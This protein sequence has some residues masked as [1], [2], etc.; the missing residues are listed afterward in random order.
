M[1][2]DP[3][4]QVGP[5]T[6]T[7]EGLRC[8]TCDYNLT[9]LVEEVCPECGN[10]FDR[11]QMIAEM[12]V[13]AAPIPIWG[14]RHEIGA[15][16]AFVQTLFE[17]WFHPIRFAKRFPKNANE[18]QALVFSRWCLG[19]SLLLVMIPAPILISMGTRQMVGYVLI[20]AGIAFGAL[21]CEWLLAAAVFIPMVGRESLRP[22]YSQSLAFVRMT[23]AFGLLSGGCLHVGG[24][25]TLIL[26]NTTVVLTCT[27]IVFLAIVVYWWACIAL[28]AKGYRKS[29]LNFL[30]GLMMTPVCVFAGWLAATMCFG[31]LALLKY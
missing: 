24:W 13:A 5:Q 6:P 14:R 25:A 29:R 1:A 20:A 7:D 30:L 23:R 28:L 9:G 8:P 2:D 16:L 10:A 3:R 26:S 11:V 15:P 4:N 21:V 12:S 17:I 22:F 19:I 27:S 18:R 31:L